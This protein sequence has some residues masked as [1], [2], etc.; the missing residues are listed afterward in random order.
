MKGLTE[1]P[2]FLQ[3]SIKSTYR[4]ILQ[5][6]ASHYNLKVGIFS[7]QAFAYPL[8]NHISENLISLSLLY[9]EIYTKIYRFLNF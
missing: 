1:K 8:L 2:F 7:Y 9:I 3:I 5:L 4:V 6:A